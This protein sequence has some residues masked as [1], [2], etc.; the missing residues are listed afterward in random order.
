MDRIVVLIIVVGIF[1]GSVQSILLQASRTRTA[2]EVVGDR[3]AIL[4]E[5][6][7]GM[8]YGGVLETVQAPRQDE[9]RGLQTLGDGNAPTKTEGADQTQKW[10]VVGTGGGVDA[11]VSGDDQGIMITY[12]DK[13]VLYVGYCLVLV[14]LNPGQNPADTYGILGALR[15]VVVDEMGESM[16]ILLPSDAEPQ[17]ASLVGNGT[18][19][20]YELGGWGRGFGKA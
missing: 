19:L 3:G 15:A 7:G 11:Y 8:D 5:G 13:R 2:Q 12:P 14:K 18:I 9:V 4:A 6:K 1:V 20:S 17:L 16:S 10:D